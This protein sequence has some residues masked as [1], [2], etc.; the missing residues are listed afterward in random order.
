MK[1]AL[2][3]PPT[4]DMEGSF[5]FLQQISSAAFL[6]HDIS[7]WLC[8]TGKTTAAR[9]YW[10]GKNGTLFCR[11]EDRYAPA[12]DDCLLWMQGMYQA[13]QPDLLI[14]YGNIVGQALAARFAHSIA[15]SC[16][17]QAASIA[18][19]QAL[20]VDKNVCSSNVVWKKIIDRY[21][22]VLSV[23]PEKAL[24]AGQQKKIDPIVKEFIGTRS[25]DAP[26]TELIEPIAQSPLEQSKTVF[27]GGRG[28]GGEANARKLRELAETLGAAVGF[29]RPAAMNG[30][31][32]MRETVGQSGLRIAPEVCVAFGVS[33][34]A[35]FLAGVRRAKKLVAVNIDRDAP[36]FA[37]ADAGIIADAGDVLDDWLRRAKDQSFVF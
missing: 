3:M 10:Q 29:S 21:P 37:H 28:L 22:C 16:F 15:G 17:S 27:I 6:Q 24:A 26:L 13:E 34:C 25:T 23:V 2:V 19:G 18:F 12:A 20:R 5:Q 35:A 36:I 1:I 31:G 11:A 4:P 30:W 33:G 8:G 32:Q 9:L 14:F 7:A